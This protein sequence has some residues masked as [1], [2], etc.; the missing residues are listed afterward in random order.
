MPPPRTENR[1]TQASRSLNKVKLS[2][3]SLGYCDC[4]SGLIKFFKQSK[5]IKEWKSAADLMKALR[6]CKICLPK[7][8]IQ[9]AEH[10]IQVYYHYLKTV[11]PGKRP[12]TPTKQ[13]QPP[14]SDNH[15][16]NYITYGCVYGLFGDNR[17]INISETENFHESTEGF[18]DYPFEEGQLPQ[19]GQGLILV[20]KTTEDAGYNMHLGA[21]LGVSSDGLIMTDYNEL[22]SGVVNLNLLTYNNTVKIKHVDD[23][24]GQNYQQKQFALGLLQ[25]GSRIEQEHQGQ[26]SAKRSRRGN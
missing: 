4:N 14:C 18:T 15:T 6:E 10:V 20:N 3:Q 1:K 22:E 24:R 16:D 13:P 19:V 12:R 9:S 17:S 26:P 23:F 21:V 25:M 7:S 2:D 11:Q 5:G 8:C